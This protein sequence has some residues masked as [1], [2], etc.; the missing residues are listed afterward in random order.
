MTHA[1]TSLS[2]PTPEGAIR[3]VN[4]SRVAGRV[5]FSFNDHVPGDFETESPA[6]GEGASIDDV[7]IAGFKFGPVRNL[8]ASVSNGEVVL[9]WTTPAASTA[10]LAP[11]DDRAIAY[12]I[13]RSPDAQPYVWTEV[14]TDRVSA[15]TFT[16]PAP[17]DGASRYVVQAWDEGTGAGYGE[18]DLAAAARATVIPPV[19]V[20]AITGVTNGA[21]YTEMPP[22]TVSRDTVKGTT[23]YRWDSGAYVA[24]GAQSFAVTP[25]AGT[26]TL[27]VYST[28]TLGDPELPH[29]TLTLTVSLPVPPVAPVT[30]IAVVGTTNSSGV[31]VTTP[32]ITITRDQADGTTFYRWVAAAAYDSTSAASFQL[33]AR[34]GTHTLEV[35]S[36]VPGA[37]EQTIRTRTITVTIAPPVVKPT[38]PSLSTPT[39][40]TSYPR[41]Y[42]SFYIRGTVKPS[43][44]GSTT[45]KLPLYRYYSGSY[46]FVKTYTL[47]LAKG[48]TSYSLKLSLS[49]KSAYRVRAQH[50]CAVHIS[51]YSS[52]K[53]F[54]V[55]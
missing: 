4:L 44:T 24:N 54:Y 3:P 12:R 9:N 31:Y 33:P 48:A 50:G 19:P 23:F 10:L 49:K 1:A 21:T 32:T 28:N 43:H 7:T 15:T 37:E 51:T 42:R 14:T 17:L 41:R 8:V 29:K 35:Y 39:I 26:H 5:R 11:P 25:L 20:S 40:S 38:K 55:H 30:T 16:D 18:V 34:A 2:A 47:T 13:W 52:Y 36:S 45:V 22:I 6:N 27:E 46:H 53:K